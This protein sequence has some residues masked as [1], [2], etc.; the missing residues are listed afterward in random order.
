[1][2]LILFN[3]AASET[4]PVPNVCGY[5]PVIEA[6]YY[7]LSIVYTL[8]KRLVQM[9]RKLG[10]EEVIIV[11]DLAIHAKAQEIELKQSGEFS[12][13]VLMMGAFHTA[14][15]FIAVIGKRFGDDVLSD[16]LIESGIVAAGSISVAVEGRR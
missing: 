1:M 16:L 4:I 2:I 5:C 14:M 11:L 6:L 3:A 7:Q 13:V 9:S 12:D 8:L 10:L 15:T